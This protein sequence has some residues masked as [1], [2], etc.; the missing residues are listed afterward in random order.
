MA[1]NS[2]QYH[3][4]HHRKISNN[5]KH[6]KLNRAN[7]QNISWQWNWKSGKLNKFLTFITYFKKDNILQKYFI[8][9]ESR[10]DTEI[11]HT[12]LI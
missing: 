6:C 5:C 12:D 1:Q 11:A 10:L 2:H 8:P 9:S 3:H 4:R 7:L